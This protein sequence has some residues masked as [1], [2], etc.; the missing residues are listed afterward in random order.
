MFPSLIYQFSDM[1]KQ[2]IFTFT[3][4]IHFYLSKIPHYLFSN[5]N[6]LELKFV[7]GSVRRPIN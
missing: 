5:R 2:R 1:L 4:F 7:Y 3:N 6:S